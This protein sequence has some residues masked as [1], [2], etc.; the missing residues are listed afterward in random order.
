VQPQ[1][2]PLD[3]HDWTGAEV[4]DR[5]RTVK[6]TQTVEFN[7]DTTERLAAEAQRRGITPI[8]LIQKFV[9]DG[10]RRL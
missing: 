6:I 2:D 8:A 3:S 9:H 1:P 10:L 7:R 4:D 5:P